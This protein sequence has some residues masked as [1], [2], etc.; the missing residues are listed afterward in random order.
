MGALASCLFFY[1]LGGLTF[2]PLVVLSLFVHAYI[3]LPVRDTSSL[4]EDDRSF[5]IKPGDDTD[6]I[7]AERKRLE[8]KARVRSHESD[9]A[10]GYFAVCR[11]YVPGGVNGKPPERSS[12]AGSTT[13]SASS[14]SVYQSIYRNIFDRKQTN[15]PLDNKGTGKPLKKGGNVFYVVLRYRI[16]FCCWS[17]LANRYLRHGHLVLFDDDDQIEVRHVISL[18]HHNVS[19]YSGSEETPEGELFIKRNAICLSRKAGTGNTTADSAE[20]KPFFLFSDNCSD[21][22]DFYFTLLRNQ[23]N[24]PDL[25]N[26]P[27]T[28]LQ[29]DVKDIITLVQRLHSSEEHLQT[30]W[31]N[32]VI[33]RIFLALYRTSEVEDFVRAKIT[34]KISRVKTP[35][36]LSKIVLRHID[37][38]G[39]APVITNPRLKDLTVDGELVVEAD[40]R[41]AGNFRIEV[42]TTARIELGTRFKARE[43]NL[44]L[45]VVMK[46]LEGHALI[47]VKPPPS[48]RIWTS[49]QTMPKIDMTIEPIVS[50]R[51]ITYTLILRQ[52]ENRIKE[53][54]AE[55]LVLPN[56]DDMPFYHSE[57]KK[58][59]GGIWAEEAT[60]PVVEEEAAITTEDAAVEEG[61]HNDADQGSTILALPQVEKSIS[62]PLI[63]ATSPPGAYARKGD[64]ASKSAFPRGAASTGVEV[65]PSSA[66]KPR[67]L[68]KSSFASS[69]IVG[70]DITNVD[71]IKNSLPENSHASAMAAISAL[72]HANS[73][74]E[75]PSLPAQKENLGSR[76]SRSSSASE[77]AGKGPQTDSA[78][79]LPP[80]TSDNTT[81]SAPPSPTSLKSGAA[82]SKGSETQSLDPKREKSTTSSSKS[83]STESKKL[84][85]AAVTSAAAAN[86]RKWGLNVLQRHGDTKADSSS[87]TDNP[88]PTIVMGRGRPLPP[89]GTPLPGTREEDE[90]SPNS[91]AQE[92]ADPPA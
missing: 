26:K 60:E 15:S 18:H 65:R 14:P 84:S 58:W 44:L 27:P 80:T 4:A 30:R 9:V 82:S 61:D 75:S 25:E 85:L 66:D 49:F 45:A 8:G 90:D 2:I 72:S 70:T 81:G 87:E 23:A 38:G 12:P 62:M 51:Q 64:K 47:R 71:A 43:V 57:S 5:I 73:P 53:V 59:R 74:S 56:W 42:A 39:A 3:T 33:G 17:N 32:A 88:A 10:A 6:A 79:K 11:E 37:M 35:A 7:K 92:E 86:A 63:D 76:S 21:K 28:P 22:E 41:Y 54:I 31:I 78:L 69:P 29:Y 91:R 1:L 48:N 77:Q 13:I 40:V 52:I 36:F 83:S 16:L 55:S 68:R 19:I 46:R 20:S 24:I 67:V 34:K 50:S 89:P